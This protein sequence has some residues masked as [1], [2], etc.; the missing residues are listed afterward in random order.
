M[1]RYGEIKLMNIDR[2]NSELAKQIAYV[3]QFKLRDPRVQ[4]MLTVTEVQTTKDL[5]FSTVYVSYFGDET[6]KESTIVALNRCANYIRNEVK[7]LVRIRV[8][9]K[10]I[11]KPD[12]SALY[13]A[14]MEKLIDDAKK[15]MV[16]FEDEES[17]ES[18]DIELDE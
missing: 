7:D 3:I 12:D 16:Y 8:M 14:K 4:G 11:F 1:L 2:V 17:D 13:G 9:P 6:K 10:L 15:S 18:L 5:S